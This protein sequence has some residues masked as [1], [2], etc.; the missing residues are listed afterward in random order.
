MSPTTV[1][2]SRSQHALAC[3][4]NGT[5]GVVAIWS[6]GRPNTYFGMTQAPAPR[7]QEDLRAEND[8]STAM[9]IAE[10]PIPSTTTRLSRKNAGSSPL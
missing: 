1:R 5:F 7:G 4:G 10:L 9:S 8:A 6:S 2:T 3:T